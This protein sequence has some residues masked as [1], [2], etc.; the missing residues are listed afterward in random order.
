MPDTSASGADALH[1][2]AHR[3]DDLAGQ[4]SDAAHQLQQ[5][6]PHA[7]LRLAG[8]VAQEAQGISTLAQQMP[9]DRSRAPESVAAALEQAGEALSALGSAGH[10]LIQLTDPE[11]VDP[12]FREIASQGLRSSLRYARTNLHDAA[13]GLRSAAPSDDQGHVRADAAL[14]RTTPRLPQ[15]PAPSS[16]P[17]TSFAPLRRLLGRR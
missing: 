5:P 11:G 15:P 16:P 2:T 7:V 4:V 10:L 9:H 6:D 13:S 12:G 8:H 17:Q 1:R 3:L 14:L